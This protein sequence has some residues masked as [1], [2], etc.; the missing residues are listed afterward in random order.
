M[1]N[2]V[3][4][5]DFTGVES[6]SLIPVGT[7]T[8]KVIGAEFKKATTGS[9]QLEL[10]F[11]SNEGSTRKAWFSLLPQALW[12]VKQVLE[13]LGM[14]CEGRVKI[15]TKSLIG[16]SCQITVE[17]DANDETRQIVT[18]VQKLGTAV[19]VPENFTQ[20]ATAPIPTAQPAWVPQAGNSATP[21]PM[22]NSPFSAPVQEQPQAQPAAAPAPAPVAPQQPQ[23][24][25][26]P[27]MQQAAG[28]TAPQGNLPPWMKQ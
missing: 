19:P 23:G 26:P 3:M 6:F 24:N 12:R 27:W 8:A 7:H 10:N 16:K 11:E 22:M 15:N 1:S 17:N 2:N 5:L 28:N 9:D 21:S 20:G 4:E 13:A 25:L 18:K 14:S